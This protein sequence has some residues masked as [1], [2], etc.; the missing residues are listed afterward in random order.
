MQG[1]PCSLQFSW[2]AFGEE[3]HSKVTFHIRDSVKTGGALRPVFLLVFPVLLPSCPSRRWRSCMVLHNELLW[4]TMA[5]QCLCGLSLSLRHWVKLQGKVLPFLQPASSSFRY[6][7]KCIIK[8]TETPKVDL[9]YH[10]KTRHEQGWARPGDS[11]T[12]GK[13][14]C[15]LP[16][17]ASLFSFLLIWRRLELT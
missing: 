16:A 6:E 7:H 13:G 9:K 8:M 10:V 4:E 3:W 5:F 11:G 2:I 17:G 15:E 14:T 1:T 12:K